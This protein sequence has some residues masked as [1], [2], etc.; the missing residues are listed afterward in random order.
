MISHW[1]GLNRIWK[2]E[3]G[4]PQGSVLG[5]LLFI[6]YLNDLCLNIPNTLKL[7]YADD[8][9]IIHLQFSLQDQDQ[10]LI[11]MINIVEV[12]FDW[13]NGN[14]LSMN[15]AKTSSMV[16]GTDSM[17]K[18]I[19]VLLPDKLNVSAGL[20]A[21]VRTAKNLGMYIDANLNWNSHIKKVKKNVNSV[22]YHLRLFRNY[23]S[24]ELRKHLVSALVL[25]IL[26]RTVHSR[27]YWINALDMYLILEREIE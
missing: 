23:T 14:H 16:V 4:V 15:L 11:T 3:N 10:T 5:P 22:L 9:Q 2:I 1:S 8:L 12:I 7:I 13:C 18:K 24:T 6:I 25:P 19:E 27:N 20:I 26:A 21:L 17:L